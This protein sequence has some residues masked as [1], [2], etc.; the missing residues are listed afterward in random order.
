MRKTGLLLLFFLLSSCATTSPLIGPAQTEFDVVTDKTLGVQLPKPKAW[1]SRWLKTPVPGL[2]INDPETS[3]MFLIHIA[4]EALSV[5]EKL[6]AVL[7]EVMTHEPNAEFSRLEG[8]VDG[9]TASGF[10]AT[11]DGQIAAGFFVDH[12]RGI[13]MIFTKADIGVEQETIDFMF[14]R[15]RFVD[16]K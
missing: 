2:Q 16:V 12:D 9:H 1:T 13:Y 14:Q 3:A 5:R 11:K 10:R 15:L 7:T 6:D 4:P 8:S